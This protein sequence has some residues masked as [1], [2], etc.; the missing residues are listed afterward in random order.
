MSGLP[1]AGPGTEPAPLSP[2]PETRLK[3]PALL[4]RL[5]GAGGSLS[6]LV[7]LRVRLVWRRFVTG[8]GKLE[9]MALT[10]LFALAVP[11]GFVFAVLVGAGSYRAAR[12]GAGIELQSLT[13]IFF[14]LW[15]AWTALALTLSDREVL[16]LKRYLSFPIP[17]GRAYLFGLVS[18]LFGDPAALF[19]LI[20][21]SGVF[22]GAALARPGPW[23]VGL[24]VTLFGF[25][26]ATLTL[27]ALLQEL[28]AWMLRRRGVRDLAIATLIIAAVSLM[29]SA[30]SGGFASLRSAIVVMFRVR[31]VAFPAALSS[32]A[33]LALYGHRPLRSLPWLALLALATLL[34]GWIA[35]RLA[36][37]SALSGGDGAEVRHAPGRLARLSFL[38]GQFGALFEKD[39]RLLTRHPLVRVYGVVVPALACIVTWQLA[40]RLP[41]GTREMVRGVP[42]LSFAI[43]THLV[44]QIFWLNGFG[45][46]RGGARLLY[47]APVSPAQVLL[48]KN[49]ALLVVSATVFTAAAALALL[50]GD[51]PPLWAV[52]AAGVL[53]LAGSPVLF[54]LGNLVGVL[55]PKAASFGLKRGVNVSSLSALAGMGILS[56][57]ASLFGIPVLI[58][59]R[60]G[61]PWLLSVGWAV[62]GAVAFAVYWRTLPAAGRL[63]VRRREELLAVVSGDPA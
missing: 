32:E 25:A 41:E 56:V 20:L 36:L 4:A 62:V 50:V 57:A 44:L 46:E 16:D 22:G 28:L 30:V 53:Q 15:Q 9:A 34:A 19:W 37:A 52:V 26:A 12:S 27:I 2:P 13:V 35:F 51:R 39:L 49:L 58:A 48:S 17:P 21:L 10:I 33:A 5:Y 43:Y 29:A 11:L 14:G 59:L 31:W 55:N 1:P 6:P 54:G 63:L 8:K 45:W 40:P 24:A 47:V 7:E 18:G 61:E 42:L 23:L 38:R 60:L 3:L